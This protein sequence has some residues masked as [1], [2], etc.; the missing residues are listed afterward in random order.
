LALDYK[1]VD[2]RR[3]Y[4]GIHTQAETGSIRGSFG[5]IAH[6]DNNWVDEPDAARN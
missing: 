4:T 6:N 2:I 1:Q 3:N 5:N